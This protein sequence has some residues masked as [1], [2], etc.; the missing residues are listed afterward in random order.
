MGE[1]SYVPNVRLY[2]L[3]KKTNTLIP[4]GSTLL[5]SKLR[6]MINALIPSYILLMLAPLG[7]G[8][9][10]MTSTFNTGNLVLT[11][12]AQAWPPPMRYWMGCYLM[13]HC[14]IV[15]NFP[16]S[17]WQLDPQRPTRAVVRYFLADLDNSSADIAKAW[18]EI[19]STTSGGP[20]GVTEDMLSNILTISHEMAVKTIALTSQLNR[21]GEVPLWQ[22]IWGLMTVC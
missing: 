3:Y 17:P 4:L 7:Q 14:L 5:G 6:T 2:I 16:S 11:A 19:G 8:R 21:E 10:L 20:K 15:W 9:W 13:P 18:T 1:L 22:K 12:Y